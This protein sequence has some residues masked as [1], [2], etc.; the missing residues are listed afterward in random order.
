MH[1]FSIAACARWERD[2]IVEWVEYHRAIG[3]D[4]FYIYSNDD[5][6]ETLYQ[7][8]LP[9]L[10]GP[11]PLVTYRHFPYLGQQQ[12]MYLHILD[13]HRAETEWI[14]FLDIDEFISLRNAPD[15]GSFIA[16][17]A[18]DWDSVYINWAFFGHNGHAQRSQGSVLRN[19]TRR[20]AALHPFTKTVTRAALLDPEVIRAIRLDGFW[21]GWDRFGISGSEAMGVRACNVLGEPMRHYYDDFPNAAQ[22]LIHDPVRRARLFETAIVHHYAFKS[23]D[24]FVLRAQR[25]TLGNFIG[26]ATWSRMHAEGTHRQFLANIN[27]VE[28][29]TLQRFWDAYTANRRLIPAVPPPPGIN[30]SHGRPAR[31]SS[32]CEYSIGRTIEEDAARAV[33]GDL[34]AP[35]AFH[36]D[37]EAQPWWVVDLVEVCR[38]RQIR[39]FNRVE[40]SGFAGRARTL[41]VHVSA[42]AATWVTVHRHDPA[43]NFGGIDGHPLI[44]EVVG[45]AARFV[46]LR[47]EEPGFFHLVQV[48]VYG[49]PAGH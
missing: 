29:R 48:E 31:Q 21:H 17:Y 45:L 10:H 28:D 44:I 6:P 27:A 49:D 37:L 26:Q 22:A 42:D 34:T 19:Y 33:N 39:V 13:N 47:L 4:H 40:N 24:D 18:A 16:R 12:F 5:D 20:E 36:T 9:Y 35:Y 38:L 32:I 25:G 1:R 46:T 15:I 43:R 23:E 3:F 30:L 41:S 8:L 7:V 11:A 2:G 14:S